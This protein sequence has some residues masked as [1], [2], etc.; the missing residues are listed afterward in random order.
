MGICKLHGL[1]GYITIF[2][3]LFTECKSDHFWLRYSQNRKKDSTLGFGSGRGCLLEGGVYW[4]FYCN[5]RARGSLTSVSL[6][7]GAKVV[8]W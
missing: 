6:Q 2:Q 7:P 3:Q 8:C 1:K 4:V 5:L